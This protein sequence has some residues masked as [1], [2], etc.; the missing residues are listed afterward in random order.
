[1]ESNEKTSR[2]VRLA[3]IVTSKK[4]PE[5][6]GKSPGG[7]SDIPEAEKD[8]PCLRAAMKLLAFSDR[9]EKA[10]REKLTEKGFEKEEIKEVTEYLKGKKYLSDRRLMESRVKYLANKKLYG[11]Q[12]I[13][14]ELI[15]YFGS[16]S[17]KEHGAAAISEAEGDIDFFE[18]AL[19]F[20][21]GLKK[22]G[23]DRMYIL[24]KLKNN[25]FSSEEIRYALEESYKG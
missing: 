9:S 25:G 3:D 20:A 13:K 14:R 24:S 5:M 8:T 16:E 7:P 21:K 12:R 19:S 4:P 1:M 2:S 22:R 18:N 17:V 11:M 6:K 23:K 10:L 15:L